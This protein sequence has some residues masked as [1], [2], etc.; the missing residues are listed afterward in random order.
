MVEVLSD[1]P[2]FVPDLYF[3]EAYGQADARGPE[4]EWITIAASSGAWQM[5]VVL[6]D[7]GDG[8]R[9]AISPYGYSGIHVAEGVTATDAASEWDS[10]R[11][12]LSGLGVVSLFLRFSPLDANSVTMAEWFEGLTI[13]RS[14]TTYVVNIVDPGQMWEGLRSSCRSRIR[15]ALRNG[16]T[17]EVRQAEG[18]DLAPGGD[19]CRLYEQTMQR[20]DAAPLYFFSDAYYKA[21]L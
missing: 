3:T 7:L 1:E 14:G 4:G 13:R 5:P 17:G 12:L 15:K 2:L 8:L 10:A 20:L 11:E 19:F 21:L 18:Q 16:Y 9:E 6:T